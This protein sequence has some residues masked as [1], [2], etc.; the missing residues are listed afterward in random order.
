MRLQSRISTHQCYLLALENRITGLKSPAFSQAERA[1]A[2]DDC[3]ASI[4]RLSL[5][6]KD[7]LP[8]LATYD[9]R[10]YSE[11]GNDFFS[12]LAATNMIEP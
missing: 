9:Q 1:S 6:V 10:A 8:S 7:N 2:I 5:A 3:L 11:V 4:S 12:V